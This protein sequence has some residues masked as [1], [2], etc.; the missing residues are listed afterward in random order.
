M[1]AVTRRAPYPQFLKAEGSNDAGC[2]EV[3]FHQGSAGA[4]DLTDH[5]T[6]PVPGF[7][8][9]R[10]RYRI[11]GVSNGE[12]GL[13]RKA[14]APGLALAC[15]ARLVIAISADGGA[16]GGTAD[17]LRGRYGTMGTVEPQ[18]R[19]LARVRPGRG[20]PGQCCGAP[21]PVVVA[22]S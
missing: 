9:H 20:G 10:W 11:E 1:L 21:V 8:D 2:A 6:G 15:S 16:D 7:T 4:G 12:P 17:P 3:A 13:P 14:G 22:Q 5:G 18:G 19:Y